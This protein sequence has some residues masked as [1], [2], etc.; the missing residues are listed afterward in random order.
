MY[1]II[2][3]IVFVLFLIVFLFLLFWPIS[4]PLLIYCIIRKK[5]NRNY[6]KNN[7]VIT[8][9]DYIDIDPRDLAGFD[10]TD[11]SKLKVY[12]FDIFDR[13][14]KAYNSLD[15]NTLYNLSTSELYN[16]YH[17]KLVVNTKL[18]EKA[19]IEAIELKK[20]IIFAAISSEK[21]QKVI[22][23]IEMSYINYTQNSKGK[24]LRGQP[25]KKIT[26]K[27]E[28]EFI[29]SLNGTENYR[30][31]NCGANTSGTKCDYCNST[32]DCD[33]KISSIRKII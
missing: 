26:E 11:V 6:F 28:V 9:H 20:M 10:I 8:K 3:N 33:F 7:V 16:K 4:I 5:Q 2:F 22:T 21:Q 32:I 13:F 25:N 19:I 27:F 23:V 15:Y 17:T 14:E 31:P 29:K 24:I 18:D 1:D 30:C 12:L